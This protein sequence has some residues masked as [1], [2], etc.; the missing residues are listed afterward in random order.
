M[1][2][3]LRDYDLGKAGRGVNDLVTLLRYAGQREQVAVGEILLLEAQE[4]YLEL[5]VGGS[6]RIPET[7]CRIDE[8]VPPMADE[9]AAEDHRLVSVAD[10]RLVYRIG[11]YAAPVR[12]RAVVSPELA[13]DET[14]VPVAYPALEQPVAIELG[15]AGHQ[16]RGQDEG[17]IV[18]PDLRRAVVYQIVCVQHRTPALLVEQVGSIHHFTIHGLPNVYTCRQLHTRIWTCTARRACFGAHSTSK[19]RAGRRA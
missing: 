10:I 9:D 12:L 17:V 8:H 16:T 5:R 7:R 11:A 13:C 15:G 14:P 19:E 1:G 18:F 4:H 6:S 3:L 2:R